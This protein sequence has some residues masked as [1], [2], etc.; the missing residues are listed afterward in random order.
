MSRNV[1]N[2]LK[3]AHSNMKTFSE[4]E[5]TIYYCNKILCIIACILWNGYTPKFRILG[6]IKCWWEGRQQ[7]LSPN[8]RYFR[9]VWKFPILTVPLTL[10]IMFWIFTLVRW[11]IHMK[12]K[13]YIK[14]WEIQKSLSITARNSAPSNWNLK[15]MGKE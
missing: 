15:R 9:I 14:R 10:A 11:N 1:I 8:D 12:T 4:H 5:I 13:K 7:K 2:M 6:T 3:K